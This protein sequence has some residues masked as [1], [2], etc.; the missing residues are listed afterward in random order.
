M[1][2]LRVKSISPQSAVLLAVLIVFGIAAVSASVFA[3]VSGRWIHVFRIR[4]EVVTGNGAENSSDDGR[5]V[6]DVYCRKDSWKLTIHDAVDNVVSVDPPPVLSDGK[7]VAVSGGAIPVAEGAS[8][9]LWTLCLE[10][11]CSEGRL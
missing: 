1:L 8:G 10:Y 2:L 3:L 4:P 7:G 5:G 6:R 11:R 9:G